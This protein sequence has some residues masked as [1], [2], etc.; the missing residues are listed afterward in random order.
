MTITPRSWIL[1]Y[2]GLAGMLVFNILPF[3]WMISSSLK[4]DI[5]VVAIPATLLPRTLTFAAYERI[6]SQEDFVRYYANSFYVSASAAFIAACVGVL[7]AYGFSR[8]RFKGRTALMVL[9]LAS[10]MIPGVLLVGPYLKMAALVGL[11]DTHLALILAQST[12][13]MPFAVWMLKGYTDTVP[14]E[15]D[16][17]ARI[18]GASHIQILFLCILPNIW[19]G[20]VATT[21]FSFLLAWGDL[22]WALCLIS[23]QNLQTMTL[24]VTQLIGQF[25]VQWSDIMAAATIG[26]AIPAVLYVILQRYLVQGFTESAVKD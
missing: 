3:F 18:D 25:R 12:L 6:W 19:P 4:S 24:G 9:F 1:I 8:F 14:L 11:Y 23:S 21:I 26:S 15:L 5:E 17:A 2:I 20:L 7:A 13:T 16:Q 10:Q 22:L